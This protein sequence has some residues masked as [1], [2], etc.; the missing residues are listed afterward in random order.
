[1]YREMEIPSLRPTWRER[2]VRYQLA[3]L[4]TMIVVACWSFFRFGVYVGLRDAQYDRAAVLDEA[5]VVARATT[6]RAIHEERERRCASRLKGSWS[7]E[8][9]QCF[10]G[11]LHLEGV[12]VEMRPEGTW[13]SPSGARP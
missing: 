13:I 12:D 9:P 5:I 2:L 1:M 8:P 3:V 10:I 11:P 7:V 6:E 4:A